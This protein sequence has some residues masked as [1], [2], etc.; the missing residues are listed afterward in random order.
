MFTVLIRNSSFGKNLYLKERI[1]GREISSNIEFS[2]SEN[3][4]KLRQ[5][6]TIGAGKSGSV[7]GPRKNGKEL[8]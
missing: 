2:R 5:M 4:K 7:K 6:S 8:R 3:I 1:G